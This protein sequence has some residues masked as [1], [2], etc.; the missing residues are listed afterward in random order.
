MK[1]FRS[2]HRQSNIMRAVILAR[3][4]SREQEEGHSME[5]WLSH[6]QEYC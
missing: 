6:L 2:S 1:Y 4:S 5:A 3:V